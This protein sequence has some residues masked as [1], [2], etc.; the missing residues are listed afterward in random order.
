MTLLA[1]KIVKKELYEKKITNY[2][3]DEQDM[4]EINLFVLFKFFITGNL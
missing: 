1:Y 2:S 3:F 4:K